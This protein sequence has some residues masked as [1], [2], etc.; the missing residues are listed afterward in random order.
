MTIASPGP[1]QI[2]PTWVSRFET[3]VQTLLQD[4]WARRSRSLMW[5]KVMDVRQSS[6]GRDLLFWL[7]ETARITSEGFGGNKRFDDIGAAV[8]EIVNA[9]SGAGL[10]LTTNEIKDNQMSDAGLRGMPA[11][12]FAEAWARQM[13]S[14]A[15]YW[16]QQ[17][18]FALIASG[19]TVNG[20]DGVP[21]FS[22]AH[23]V[24]GF[25]AGAGTYSNKISGKPLKVV[26]GS[27]FDV[28]AMIK[29]FS[30]IL[31]S[32]RLYTQ[33]NGLPRDVQFKYAIG[34]PDMMMPL[35]LILETKTFGGLAG[36]GVNE[37][38]VSRWGI[39][40]LIVPELAEPGVVYLIAEAIPGEGG[41]FI[42]QERDPYVLST[43]SPETLAEL[44]RRKEFAWHYDGR[45]AA[46][47][48]HPYLAVRV[49]AT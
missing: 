18:L 7:L 3:N 20:Y 45:N 21:F 30:D 33:P 32:I 35:S 48:G 22:T 26:S 47:F 38:I 15:A 43:Y 29:N 9:N 4:S 28:P 10:R 2:T 17:A 49:E 34:G 44:N 14:S 16:P 42:F 39:E 40:P 23:P 41:A 13:G 36:S 31:S 6:T 1:T 5:D 12:N 37:N 11:L 27:A 8:N 25:N 24:N 46:A 19:T